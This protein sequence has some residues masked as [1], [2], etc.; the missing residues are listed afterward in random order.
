[1][2]KERVLSHQDL[3]KALQR[4]L[5]L[6]REENLSILGLESLDREGN[7]VG[8]D[9]LLIVPEGS[10]RGLSLR[11]F[12]EDEHEFEPQAHDLVVESLAWL[13]ES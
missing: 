9:L 1:M 10:E 5:K 2:N 3:S 4:V 8:S 11:A 6:N 7:K 12:L 13:D